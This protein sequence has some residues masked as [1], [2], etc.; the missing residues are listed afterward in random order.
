MEHSLTIAIIDKSVNSSRLLEDITFEAGAQDV[1]IFRSLDKIKP[2]LESTDIDVIFLQH[3]VDEIDN[4]YDEINALISTKHISFTTK[5]IFINS[6]N[7]NFDYTNE[8]PFHT[9]KVLSKGITST[10]I[11]KEFDEHIHQ[12]HEFKDAYS[13]IKDEHYKEAFLNL[14]ELISDA[15]PVFIRRARNQLLVNLLIQLD[16]FSLAKN[17]LTPLVKKNIE[18]ASWSLF[19]IQ[20]ELKEFEQC[21]KFLNRKDIQTKYP[22]RSLYWKISLAFHGQSFKNICEEIIKFDINKITPSMLR[23]S[24]FY[25]AYQN[26]IDCVTKMLARKRHF[27]A[28]N[29]EYISFISYLYSKVM[30]LNMLESE[31]VSYLK[32]VKERI[33]TANTYVMKYAPS[34][35]NTINI[36]VLACEKKHD[37]AQQELI[38]LPL[39]DSNDPAEYVFNALLYSKF[40]DEKTAFEYL[41]ISNNLIASQLK[42]CHRVF[43]SFM[44]KLV[45]EIIFNNKA[46]QTQA[47]EEIGKRLIDMNEHH[48]ALKLYGHA[49]RAGLDSANI[50]KHAQECAR[51]CGINENYYEQYLT[52]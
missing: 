28:N 49:C 16:Q 33:K 10:A 25:L 36:A 43:T 29:T 7:L 52:M 5:I 13:L 40:G 35:M 14:K 50:K 45:F 51:V 8:Y 24:V 21:E 23:L 9:C 15:Y 48:N 31:H 39:P 19:T 6:L 18:W 47:Y 44:H 38:N 20:Y 34:K 30:L 41:Y 32:L 2:F 3:S 37:E 12:I 26:R 1:Y 42:N 27:V 46:K 22:V 17:F 11:K 4:H